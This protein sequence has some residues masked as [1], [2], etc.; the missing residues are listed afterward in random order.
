M[1]Q[2]LNGYV[3]WFCSVQVICK[4]FNYKL[5][6]VIL[7]IL[8]CGNILKKFFAVTLKE[9]RTKCCEHRDVIILRFDRISSSILPNHARHKNEIMFYFPFTDINGFPFAKGY[10]NRDLLIATGEVTDTCTLYN[11]PDEYLN[12]IKIMLLDFTFSVLVIVS[13]STSTVL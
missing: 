9:K 10:E 7:P 11:T 6:S 1:L 8:K 12:V 4:S 3:R 13:Y 2:I 5:T